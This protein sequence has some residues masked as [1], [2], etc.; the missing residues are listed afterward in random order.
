MADLISNA[1]P[2]FRARITGIVYLLYFL[3]AV[4]ADVFI[5]PSRLVFFDAVNLVAE[6]F[7]IFVSTFLPRS[8]GVLMALAGLGWLVF[9]TPLAVPLSTYLK[10]LGFLAEA[11]LMLWLVVKGV[12]EQRW[13]ERVT[14]G[15][16]SAA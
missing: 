15:Q 7:Y 2:R 9:L 8:L 13:N 6:A 12:N 4:S 3:T 1:S 14:A 5:G 10:I 11:S 16:A